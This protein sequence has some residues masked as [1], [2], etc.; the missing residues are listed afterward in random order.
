MND[1]L[2]PG[3][4]F[5]PIFNNFKFSPANRIPLPNFLT[6]IELSVEK[7]AQKSDSHQ[8]QLLRC[9]GF[10]YAHFLNPIITLPALRIDYN[11]WSI[12]DQKKTI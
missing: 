2:L 1:K 10:K 12:A 5:A 9:P 3:V 4:K 7:S 6:Y 11:G 8:I